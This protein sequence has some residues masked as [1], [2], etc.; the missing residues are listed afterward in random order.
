[1]NNSQGTKN[2][3]FKLSERS[4]MILLEPCPHQPAPEQQGQ[5]KSEESQLEKTTQ[6]AQVRRLLHSKQRER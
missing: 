3:T 4:L 6:P 1:M 2:S 5:K